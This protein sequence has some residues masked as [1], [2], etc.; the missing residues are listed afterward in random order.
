MHKV[1]VA[2]QISQ[3]GIDLLS[4]GLS[5]T[6]TPKITAEELLETIGEYDALLVRSRTQVPADVIK[7]GKKL[8]AIGRAGVGVDNI[9]VI[10]ATESGIVVL[11]S[12]EGNT[13]SAAEL[14]LALMMSL[15]RHIPSADLSLKKGEWERSKFTGSELFNKTLAIIGLGKV[16]SRVAQACRAVGMKVI[17]YDPMVTAER[18]A[19][20][21]VTKVTLDEIW[22]RADFITIHTPKTA[23]T[24]NLINASVLAKVKKGVRIVN[25][26]RGGVVDE[27][28]LADAITEGRVA[29]ASV[30]VFENEPPTG[31]PLLSIGEKV[32]LTPH[33]GASTHEAQFNVAIDLAEQIKEFL[34][35]GLAKSPVNL[36]SMRPEVMKEL[37]RFVWLAEA[38]ATVASELATGNITGLQITVQG[39]LAKKDTSPLTVAAL[40][41]MLSKR[42]AGVTY[43]NANLIAKNKGIEVRSVQSDEASQFAGEL[44]VELTMDDGNHTSATGTM[45]AHDEP[46][47]IKINS[48]P[49]NLNPAEM[50][51]FTTHKD[52]P[53]VVAKVAG[54]LAKHDINISNMSVARVGVRQDAVMVM[55]LDDEPKKE[56]LHELVTLSG[57]HTARFVSLMPL[58]ELN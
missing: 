56:V 49:I 40:R 20:L 34:L 58:P 55:G 37:G 25:V 30:D 29:G 4:D 45:L 47:I 38:M 12:P 9:D 11:N 33:L 15:A 1:L 5:V 10:A 50:M 57:I 28:A 27:K 8:K 53:G 23:E 44:T 17:A 48:H 2:D 51:L 6:Y 18:A 13:A 52:Q 46:L 22:Q 31:S 39:T 54:V 41:G 16:G 36:P 32:V 3:E 26:A 21:N 14:T 43:V 42:V 7:K 19:E 35:T 24:T